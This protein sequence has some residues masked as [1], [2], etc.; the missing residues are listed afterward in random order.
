MFGSLF[1]RTSAGTPEMLQITTPH[2]NMSSPISPF[3]KKLRETRKTISNGISNEKMKYST[4]VRLGA[5]YETC[6][7]VALNR[8]MAMNRITAGSPPGP[9]SRIMPG[10][11][12]CPLYAFRCDCIPGPVISCPF[13]INI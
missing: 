10:I 2:P 3:I 11:D 1:A 12:H 5:V 4:R 7:P 6:E 9:M 8:M 13:C